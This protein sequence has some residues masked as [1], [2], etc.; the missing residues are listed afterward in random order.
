MKKFL[1]SMICVSSLVACAAPN[2]SGP[3]PAHGMS[4]AFI[5]LA[6]LVLSPLQIAA[7]VLEGVAAVPYY[8][9]SGVHE[10]NKGLIAA[11]AQITLD[12]TYEA[13][14]GTRLSSVQESG[15]TGEVF[16]RMKHAS[17][18]FQTVLKQYGVPK[19]ENYILTSIDT[20][21]RDGY[22]LLAVVYRPMDNIQVIDKY[23]HRSVRNFESADR[24]FYEPYKVTMNGRR[25]DTVIDWAAYPTDVIATQKGQATLITMA[26]NSVVN[27]KRAEDYWGIEGRW[28]SGEYRAISQQQVNSVGKNLHL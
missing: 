7:G 23:D 15:D 12:D 6:N 8:M 27:G 16:R 1:L 22:I 2:Q 5:G 17:T 19:A 18:H 26:A 21:K 24:L 11:Q 9:S 25:L 3:S 14:Y 20:A 4:S 28:I 10:I 13:A